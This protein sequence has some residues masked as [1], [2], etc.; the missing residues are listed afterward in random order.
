MALNYEDYVDLKGSGIGQP[1]KEVSPEEDFFH[2]IYICG[3]DRENHKQILEKNGKLQIRG[4]D[5]NLDEVYM[6]V[7]HVKKV[8]INSSFDISK[9]RNVVTCGS[10]LNTNPWVGTSGRKCANAKERASIPEC[11]ECKHQI[12]VFGVL[13]EN[14]EGRLKIGEDKKPVFC[15]FVG[16]GIK[17][18]DVN[19]YLTNLA[20][21]EITPIFEPVTDKSL[22]FEKENV[23]MSKRVV[24]V[25]KVGHKRSQYNNNLLQTFLFDTGAK[26]SNKHIVSL[27]EVAKKTISKVEE[28][29]D[30]LIGV[31]GS[32]GDEEAQTQAD[33]SSTPAAAPLTMDIP[34][35]ENT[36]KVKP[37]ETPTETPKE[38]ITEVSDEAYSFDD[39]EF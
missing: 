27:I 37:E 38:I 36:N 1:K 3:R 6:I 13:C 7:T 4:V 16:R 29:L 8:R 28:K 31:K 35:M 25:I 32:E 15:F 10:K 22:K 5:Y 12:I 39:I 9:Q 34:S 11:K 17:W 21:Q 33:E 24:T 23:D 19:N 26:L 2:S 18:E 14:K 30:R 20:E